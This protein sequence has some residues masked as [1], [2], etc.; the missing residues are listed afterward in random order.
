[1]I[2]LRRYFLYIISFVFI[3]YPFSFGYANSFDR[4]PS[5]AYLVQG[6]PATFYGVNLATGY[7]SE[8]SSSMGTTSSLNAIG[9]SYSDDYIYGYSNEFRTIV[10]IGNDYQA[11]PLIINGLPDAKFY[12]GDI[13]NVDNAYYMYR[14]GGGAG[15]YKVPLGG[16]NVNGYTAERIIDGSSLNLTIFDFA[17]HP[18]SNFLYA[19]TRTGDL[20]QVDTIDGSYRNLGNVGEAGTFGAVYFDG[21]GNFYISRNDD[22]YI[23][24]IDVDAVTPIAQFFAFGPSSSTNDGARC[25]NANIIDENSMVDFG[26]APESYGTSLDGNGARHEI[27]PDV[28]LGDNAGGEKDGADFVTGFE[29]GLDTLVNVRAQGEGYLNA[30]VD[31]EQDGSFDEQDH[32]IV[33]YKTKNGD[34][35]IL[36]DVPLGAIEGTTWARFRYSSKQDVGAKGGVSDGE[37]ED[38][39]IQ[40]TP[41]GVRVVSYPSSGDFV[42][43]AYEDNWP[44]MGDYDMN[45]VVMAYRTRKYIDES[46]RVIRYDIEG[47]LLAMGAGYHNG[48]AVQLDG[49][50]TGNINKTLMRYEIN[51]INK[52][53]DSNILS[54]LEINGD[55]ETAVIIIS[56]DLWSEITV[57]DSCSYYRT[58]ED[59][60]KKEPYDFVV[61]VPLIQSMGISE[62]PSDV[63]NPFIF[64]SPGWYHGDDF[65]SPPGRSL[66][67]HLKNKPV[68]S[69]FNSDFFNLSDDYSDVLNDLTFLTGSNMPWALQMPTL[70]SHP[71]ERIDLNRAYPQFI[72]FVESSGQNSSTWYVLDYAV[73][74][75]IISN[76]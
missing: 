19:V 11:N 35:R 50:D 43:L 7:F 66:E 58:S 69:R 52:N 42:A 25:A 60:T 24:R 29:T 75:N 41:S 46:N 26:D 40:V 4:C 62:A 30:W 61:S 68:S 27:S 48:F 49:I 65:S 20:M 3:T 63:L 15:L 9:Y 8:L 37:V 67:I 54:P 57:S 59:C 45:D 22:G 13:S 53:D 39:T 12:V 56:N 44:A 70:W 10:K 23:F 71:K 14:P 1:M 51:G 36:M 21:G 16:N 55:N 38:Y 5:F 74:D 32:V 31:W 73:T 72:D 2:Y 34:N 76:E 28:Y 33:D 64:A 18:L 47:K 17:F 6:S